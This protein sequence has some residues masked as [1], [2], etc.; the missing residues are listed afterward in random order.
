MNKRNLLPLISG[1]FVAG[2]I[3]TQA[4]AE[5]DEGVLPPPTEVHDTERARET[6]PAAEK[7]E[8]LEKSLVP[9][10]EEV[11]VRAY[12]REDGSQATEYSKNGQVYMIKVQPPGD[13]PAYYLYDEDGDGT[14]E[15]RLPGGYKRPSPPMWTIKKF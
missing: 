5:E 6:I 12:T 14:M 11:Q 9:D 8:G 1:L 3:T 7:E 2:L 10:D 13:M 4:V 15:R